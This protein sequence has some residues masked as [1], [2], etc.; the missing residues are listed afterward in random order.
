MT[1]MKR[2]HSVRSNRLKKEIEALRM[3]AFGM[4]ENT[5]IPEADYLELERDSIVRARVLIDCAM[6]EEVTAIIIMD[7]VLDDSPKWNQVKYFGRIKKY[8]V[9]YDDVLGR[10]PARY[11]LGVVKKFI[12]IPKNISRTIQRMLALRDVFAHVRTLDYSHQELVNLPI[13]KKT[14]YKVVVSSRIKEN[15]VRQIVEKIIGDITKKDIDIDEIT[16]F[17]YSDKELIDGM[18]DVAKA[19][20]APYGSL[21]NVTPE[22]ARSNNRTNYKISVKVKENLEKYLQK[23]N[24][25][26]DKFGLT[27][28]KRRQIYKEIVNS[29]DRAQAE[30]DRQYPISGRSTW[31]LSQSELLNRMDKNT[32]LMRRLEEKYKFDLMKKYRITREQLKEIIYEGLS[33]NWPMPKFEIK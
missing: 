11:K 20:W 28:D 3:R 31:N 1:I 4:P 21:G 8:R 2:K 19:T 29:E 13:D 26:E 15:Q 32:E 18:Y 6:V 25:S 30:A 27:E 12:R 7:H 9:L 23:R 5:P 10:L 16:L 24:K 14:L 22:I 33:E 17:L